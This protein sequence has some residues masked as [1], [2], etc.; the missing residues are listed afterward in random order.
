MPSVFSLKHPD[1]R[2]RQI[3]G[4]ELPWMMRRNIWTGVLG[5]LFFTYM[6]WG[7]YFT[8]FCRE[9]GMEKYQFGI[10]RALIS[11]TAPLMLF[12][13][14]IEERYGQG[15]YPWFIL[16]SLSRACFAPFLI[17]FLVPLS[18]WLIIVLCVLAMALG[19]LAAPM[20]YSWTWRY[21]PNDIFG[22]FWAKRTF[23]TMLV[24]SVMGLLFGVL[25]NKAPDHYR[26]EAITVVFAVLFA[27]GF[28]DLFYHRKIPETPRAASAGSTLSKMARTLKSKPFRNWMLALTIW[29][30]S[31][32]IAGPFCVPY[33]MYDLSFQEKFFAATVLTILIPS[34]VSLA[35]LRF[36]GSIADRWDP[37]KLVVIAYGFWASIPL[38]YYLATP[39]NAMLMLGIAW[40][41]SG[42]F[43]AAVSVASPL[44]TSRLAGED[45]TMPVAMLNVM[46]SVGAAAGAALGTFIVARWGVRSTFVVSL[47]ARYTAA[48]LIFLLLVCGPALR[49]GWRGRNAVSRPAPQRK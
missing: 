32:G 42:A 38:F 24:S 45:K 12:A 49:N 15:K 36:W 34:F 6:G 17:G 1:Y 47:A 35:T 40:A 46:V 44:I 31:M 11:L 23:W 30:F 37:R 10:L 2:P 26:L 41:V 9:M 21:I 48:F 4:H 33:M 25:I 29:T 39:D 18:P 8:A 14:A 16:A 22:R 28:I 13:S 5:A 27:L 3:Q 19:R 43:P 20:W 7:I